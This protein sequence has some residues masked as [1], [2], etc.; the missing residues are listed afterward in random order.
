MGLRRKELDCL[1][2]GFYRLALFENIAVTIT[3]GELLVKC[4]QVDGERKFDLCCRGT[5]LQPPLKSA[6]Q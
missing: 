2:A 3:G 4:L 1:A 6:V 5:P